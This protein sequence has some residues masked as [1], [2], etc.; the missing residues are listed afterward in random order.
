[1]CK[2]PAVRESAMK[3]LN[4]TELKKLLKK[5]KTAGLEALLKEIN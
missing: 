2:V 3:K 1:M 4:K 5:E